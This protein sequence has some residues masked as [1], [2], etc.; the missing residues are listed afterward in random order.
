M[1]DE[2]P[3]PR[4]EFLIAIVGPVVSFGIGLCAWLLGSVLA[5]PVLSSME[6]IED[7]VQAMSGLG[8]IEVASSEV[9]RAIM[10]HLARESARVGLASGLRV[11]RF[12]GAGAEQ[13]AD[14]D[15]RALR[16][17]SGQSATLRL[18]HRGRGRRGV[19]QLLVLRRI[20]AAEQ[21]AHG[22]GRQQRRGATSDGEAQHQGKGLVHW[23]VS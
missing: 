23:A 17:D 12:N 6:A 8:S 21:A 3:T 1:E 11:P 5:S 2:P 14:A 9:G 16:G 20:A 13:W 7:P 15:R 4:A 10:I 22:A 18:R 19:L